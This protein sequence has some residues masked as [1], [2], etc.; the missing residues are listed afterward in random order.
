MSTKTCKQCGDFFAYNQSVGYAED[1]CGP[2]CDGAWTATQSLTARQAAAESREQKLHDLYD[3]LARDRNELRGAMAAD[4][5]RLR[6]AAA[7][8]GIVAGCDA[9]DEMADELARLRGLLRE[10]VDER[11]T[12]SWAAWLYEAKAALEGK[13]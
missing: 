4:D 13:P 10:V 6:L 5:E 12:K 1:L 7:R 11:S 3:E 2:Y 9:P 8:V